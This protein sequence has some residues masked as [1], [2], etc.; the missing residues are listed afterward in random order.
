M[1][2]N[3]LKA[4][5]L[6]EG[7]DSSLKKAFD[8]CCMSEE[9]K[10]EWEEPINQLACDMFD[11][12]FEVIPEKR[13]K[14]IDYISFLLAKQQADFVKKVKCMLMDD[15]NHNDYYYGYNDALNDLLEDFADIKS[16]LNK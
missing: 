14:L 10:K 13:Q 4:S 9:L 8:E 5:E 11:R 3:K 6:F 12:D 16:K 2:K 7:K 1:S 15:S